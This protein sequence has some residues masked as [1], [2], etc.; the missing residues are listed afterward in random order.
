[1]KR[2][3]TAATLVGALATAALAAPDD[4]IMARQAAMKA[5]GAA[6]KAGDFEAMNKAALEAQAAFKADTTG[7]GTLPTESSPAIWTNMAGFDA[8]MN[9]LVTKSAAADKSVFGTCKACHA[10]YRIK[11]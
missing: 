7:Q 11:N 1:M 8:I 3:L 9:E 6:A 10:D 5:I 2:I 4:D